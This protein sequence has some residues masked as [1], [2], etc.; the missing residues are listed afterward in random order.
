MLISDPFIH[1]CRHIW[2]VI[3]GKA[4]RLN[5]I[6]KF[7]MDDTAFTCLPCLRPVKGDLV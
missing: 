3:S 4:S 7:C 2:L 1:L 6:T 5:F